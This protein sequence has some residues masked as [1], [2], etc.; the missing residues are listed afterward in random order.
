MRDG[1]V[2]RGSSWSYKVQ[3]TDPATG[4]RKPK[5]VG[6]FRTRAE[7]KAERDKARH[8]LNAGTYVEQR[9]MTVAEYLEGWFAGKTTQWKR[10]TLESYREVADRYLVPRIGGDQLQALSASRL[11][12]LYADL[13][14]AGGVDGR[15]LSVRT[16]RYCHAVLHKALADAVRQQAVPM[17]VASLAE[18]PKRSQPADAMAKPAAAEKISAWTADQVRT[19]VEAGDG[20][21]MHDSF[22]LALN[23]G[24]RRGEIYGLTWADVD[25]DGGRLHVRQALATIGHTTEISTP[26]SGKSRSFRLDPTTLAVLRRRKTAQARD[27]LAWPGEWGNDLDLVFT[28][29]DG[30]LIHPTTATKAFR[31]AALAAGLPLIRYHD[32]RHTYATLAQSAGVASDASSG[33]SGIGVVLGFGLRGVSG[34]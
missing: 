6:G 1:I 17:N 26:K 18:P 25:L 27:R 16:V 20:S 28:K 23:T 11:N 12:V 34:G 8:S 33:W 4:Q 21:A 32:Q 22:L 30:T 10:S 31:R 24:M 9:K 3:V 7:A 13:L 5:W 2:Q 29:T 19:F 14:R 15:P